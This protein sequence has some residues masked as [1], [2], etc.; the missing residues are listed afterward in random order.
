MKLTFISL[1]YKFTRFFM[2][3]KYE[4]LFDT[5]CLSEVFLCFSITIKVDLWFLKKGNKFDCKQ[6]L[7]IN[8]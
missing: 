2:V 5:K 3:R 1:V 6:I 4:K 7:Y 8:L